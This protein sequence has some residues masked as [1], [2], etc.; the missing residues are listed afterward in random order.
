MTTASNGHTACSDSYKTARRKH[1]ETM[2][3]V[4]RRPP[5]GPRFA[6]TKGFEPGYGNFSG[7]A[8]ARARHMGQV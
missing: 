5:E 4:L 2:T 1:D 3:R 7:F 8:H 6:R